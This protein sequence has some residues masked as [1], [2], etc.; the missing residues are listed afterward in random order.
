MYEVA[1]KEKDYAAQSCLKWFID[2][3]VEEEANAFINLFLLPA[4]RQDKTIRKYYRRS[5]PAFQQSQK[6]WL[7]LLPAHR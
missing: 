3:Q 5:F 1:L 2:E 7:L 6:H 4:V